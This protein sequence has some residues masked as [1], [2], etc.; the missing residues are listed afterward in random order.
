[1]LRSLLFFSLIASFN[2]ES[3]QLS[4]TETY[5]SSIYED[6]DKVKYTSDRAI[7]EDVKICANTLEEMN[8]YGYGLQN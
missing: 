4:G 5:Q 3:I 2:T 1:M 8:G 7:D 6:V